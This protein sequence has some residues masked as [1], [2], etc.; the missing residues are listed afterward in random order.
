MKKYGF[1]LAETLITLAIIGICAAMLI[2]T[3]KNINPNEKSNIVMARKIVGNF[4]E[5]TK[6]VLLFNS[7]TKKINKNG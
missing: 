3:I 4:T 7:K 5:A 1:T 2:T 6:Q